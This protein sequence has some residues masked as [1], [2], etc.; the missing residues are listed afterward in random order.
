ML[1]KFDHFLNKTTMYRLVLY[2]AEFLLI[3]AFALA[4]FG[5][6]PFSP[7]ALWISTVTITA[8][9]LAFNKLFARIY[10][11]QTNMESVYI[12]ALILAL[13]ISPPALKNYFTSFGFL[14]WAS[15]WAMAAKYILAI[16]NKHLFNPVAFGVAITAITLHQSASWWVGTAS[17][18]IFVIIGGFLVI[19][20]VQ[21]EY[22]VATFLIVAL[23]SILVLTL[24]FNPITTLYSVLVRSP[25]LFFAAAML[26]EPLTMPPTRNG[27]IMYGALVGVLFAPQMHIG[28]LYMTP[29]LALLFGNILSYL[30]SPKGRYVMTLIGKKK[31][32]TGIYNFIF[33]PDKKIKFKP[34]QYFEWT[35]GQKHT[36]NRGNRRYFTIASSPTEN[37]VMLGIKFYE[38]PSSFKTELLSM[39][40]GDT[41]MASQL[42]G[43]FVLPK[44]PNVKLVFIAG[45]IG[46]TPFRSM[47]KWMVDKDEKRS[48]T[49]IYSNSN[50]EEISYADVFEQAKKKLGLKTIFTLTN[51]SN[52]SA[53]WTGEKGPINANMI[54]R[55]IPN[56]KEC[57][58]YISGSH[59]LINACKENLKILGVSK[60]KIKT[61]F[62]PGLA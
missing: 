51:L 3:V 39:N 10:N 46:V 17:M 7:L 28:S 34:G 62:F 60:S 37:E 36:D 56:F 6:L 58:F 13:I 4:V 33:R 43:D 32:G 59:P 41:L 31:I 49:L 26:T 19:R 53:N 11:V 18:L 45:G 24:G 30:L 14:F 61:D 1:T 42:A 12:T 2:Y 22:T 44:D 47:L 35:L 5:L 9:C 15:A 27:R 38:N 8:T 52:I 57:T 50:K 20:K 21:R 29:E 16:K 55:K 23:A 40:I 48:V 25:I 54:A